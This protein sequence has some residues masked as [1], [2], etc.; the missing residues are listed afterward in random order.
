MHIVL[1]SVGMDTKDQ[2]TLFFN[3][4]GTIDLEDH[5]GNRIGTFILE[6]PIVERVYI[7]TIGAVRVY[8]DVEFEGYLFWDLSIDLN[9]KE[10][11]TVTSTQIGH[12]YGN[13]SCNNNVVS[14]EVAG[15]R[16]WRNY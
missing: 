15:S 16:P 12:W 8:D 9:A 4:D 5:I 6:D 14:Y 3:D 10:M 1:T 11:A 13:G 7:S 2:V